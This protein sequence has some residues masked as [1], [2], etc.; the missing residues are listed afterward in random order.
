MTLLAKLL[1]LLTFLSPVVHVDAVSIWKEGLKVT[2]RDAPYPN[3]AS[4]ICQLTPLGSGKDDTD[5]V[6][7]GIDSIRNLMVYLLTRFWLL[8]LNA[9]MVVLRYLNLEISTSQGRLLS[10]NLNAR[11]Y[12]HSGFHV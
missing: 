10:L 8:S 11:H 5:N 3:R 6:G 12:F 2:R 4:K 1:P 9:V 7:V